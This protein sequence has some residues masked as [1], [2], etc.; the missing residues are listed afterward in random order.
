MMSIKYFQ[1]DVSSY[2]AF[3]YSG[4]GF[5][6]VQLIIYVLNMFYINN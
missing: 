2:I 5:K 4:G 3:V 1:M 6:D